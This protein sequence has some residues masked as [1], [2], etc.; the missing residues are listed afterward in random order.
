MKRKQFSVKVVCS[1]GRPCARDGVGR[2]GL[3]TKVVRTST[4]SRTHC[5]AGVM[6]CICGRPR[7]DPVGVLLEEDT[8]TPGPTPSYSA[9]HRS[10]SPIQE[11][12]V[13]SPGHGSSLPSLDAPS[14]MGI[15]GAIQVE[16]SHNWESK[17]L[18]RHRLGQT[19][20]GTLG[21]FSTNADSRH[22]VLITQ[23]KEALKKAIDEHAATTG[24][25]PIVLS[26]K[27]PKSMG[28]IEAS[29]QRDAHLH[30][31]SLR[32]AQTWNVIQRLH[33]AEESDELASFCDTVASEPS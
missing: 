8:P 2:L 5:T 30:G 6:G 3:D 25:P 16:E 10:V 24:G 15:P 11:D 31:T 12:V 27:A 29:L 22:A 21:T 18:P 26:H 23:D 1:T 17:R 32:T 19:S 9:P 7:R 28:A 4:A 33:A 20:A 14:V 13:P